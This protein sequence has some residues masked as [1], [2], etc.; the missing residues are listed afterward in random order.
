[1]DWPFV[2]ALSAVLGYLL[3]AIPTGTIVGR[4]RGV[5]LT[6]VGSG[7]TGT[8]NALRALGPGAAAVVL[9]GDLGKGAAAVLVARALGDGA[10]WPQVIAATAAIVGHSY[11]PFIGFR[12]GRGVVTGVGGL[13][14]VWPVG[15][16]AALASA[17]I[18]FATVGLTRYVSLGSLSG[19]MAAGLV[20]IGLVIFADL[21]TAYLVYGLLVPLF[22]FVSHRD[23]IR[24]LL[25]GTERKLG[26][27]A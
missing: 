9:V 5:D 14:C 12:G 16:W 8:T 13:V 25:H 3:G 10:A 20:V 11:S 4:S 1:M 17:V 7:R 26:E 22:I 15:P 19:A 23:N 2:L 6:A 24:R 18:F 21:P 27:K